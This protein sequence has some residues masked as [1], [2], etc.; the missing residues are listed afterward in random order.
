MNG[1][2]LKYFTLKPRGRDAYAV[3]SRQAMHAYARSIKTENPQLA[4]DLEAWVMDEIGRAI[5]EDLKKGVS[6]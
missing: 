4:E 3:A 1:L 6:L 2:E 5:A